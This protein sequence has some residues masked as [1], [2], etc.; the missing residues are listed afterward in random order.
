MDSILKNTKRL[1]IGFG[2]FLGIVFVLFV[3]NQFVLLYDLLY[4]IH[5]YLAIGLITI[6][7][8]LLLIILFRLILLFT[9]SPKV[10]V[11]P[12]NPSP[13][14]YDNYL[15][16]MI[17]ILKRNRHLKEID[18]DK[19]ASKEYLVTQAFNRLDDLS[20]PLIKKNANAIF[21]STAVSQNGSLDSILVLVSMIKMIWQL[22]NVY[23]TRPSIKSMGKLYLQVASIVF[24]ARTIEDSDLIEEQLEPLITSLI[25]ESIASAIPGMAPITNLVVS[26]VLEGSLNAFLTLRVGIITQSYLGMEVPQSKSFIRRN[27]SLTSVK[28]M[29]SIIKDN[30]KIVLKTIANSV[31]KVGA[32][33]AKSIFKPKPKEQL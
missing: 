12:E 26:S 5:P 14:Q 9:R 15:D 31:K 8:G 11:L 24:M 33:K 32:Q 6:L 17:S 19:P 28:Y 30:S 16:D 22:A 27:A 18:F 7:G 21:L 3:I 13:E 23:Q 25:G 20:F 1:L 10:V 29:G 4:R 2:F